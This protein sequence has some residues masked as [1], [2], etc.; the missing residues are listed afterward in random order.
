MRKSVSFTLEPPLLAYLQTTKGR[1]SRSQRVNE[2]LKRAILLERYEKLEQ[3][4]AEFFA[5]P[6]KQERAAAR[7]FQQASIK[8]I[9]RD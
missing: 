2:L 9:A 6:A 5:A 8:S 4:A 3:E 7:A 1:G